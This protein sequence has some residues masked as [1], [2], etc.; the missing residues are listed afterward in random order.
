VRSFKLNFEINAFIYD[1]EFVK[2]HEDIFE[3]DL[4]ASNEILMEDFKNRAWT[5]KI[6][7]S[8]SR[9]LSPLL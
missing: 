7:E 6:K 1:S 9:L 5:M 2:T 4:E 3:K 8:F